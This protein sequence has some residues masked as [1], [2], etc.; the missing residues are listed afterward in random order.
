MLLYFDTPM[1]TAWI[2]PRSTVRV[3]ITVRVV[4]KPRASKTRA[5]GVMGDAVKIDIAAP[6]VDG[7][8]NATLVEFFARGLKIPK[9]NVEIVVGESG[10]RK[11]V[12]LTGTTL[13]AVKTLVQI[14]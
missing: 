5:R 7:E 13:A 12:R 14:P 9:A 11:V 1:T 8:A 6:P 10:R 2:F 4:A 3:M